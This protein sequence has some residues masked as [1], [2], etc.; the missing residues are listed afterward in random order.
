MLSLFLQRWSVSK[1]V[2]VFDTLA[3]QFFKRRDRV[4]NNILRRFR[5]ALRC[6]I[7]DGCYEVSDLEANLRL[8]FGDHHKVFDYTHYLANT[9]VAVTATLVSDASPVIFSNYNGAGLRSEDCGT[10]RCPGLK[11]LLTVG[12]GYKHFRPQNIEKEVC[13]WE[14]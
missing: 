1:C 8:Q 9:K 7:A 3:K 6:W 2:H 14:A 13:V 11:F 10:L 4:S 5:S 12:S